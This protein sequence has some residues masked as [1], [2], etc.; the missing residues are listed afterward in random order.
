MTTEAIVRQAQPAQLH[1]RPVAELAPGVAGLLA[2]PGFVRLCLSNGLAQSFGQRMQGIAVAWLVLEMTGST[3]WL[4]VVNGVPAISIVL[5]SLVG[6]VVADSR[7][8]RRVLL[9]TRAVLT[10]TAFVTAVLVATGGVSIEH[11][12]LYV[13]IVVGVAAIDMP[14]SRN[15][16]HD[17]VGSERLLSASS[18]QSVLMNLVNIVAPVTI[19]LLIS[20]GGS[21]MA[22]WLLGVGYAIAVIL[23]LRTR[24]TAVERPQKASSPLSDIAAGLGYIRS[25]PKV[26]ALVSLA[27]L[28]PVAGVYFAMVP[29]YARDVLDVGAT[30][31]GVLVASFSVGSLLGSLYLAANGRIARGTLSLTI[32]GVAFGAGMIVFSVS[33][34]FLLSC[35]VSFGMGLMAGFWQNMLGALV[36]T[37]AAPEMRGRVTSVSTMGYQLMGVG[38]LLGGS[39]AALVGVQATVFGAGVFF[40]AMSLVVFALNKEARWID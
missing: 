11:L 30:G 38:W 12:L 2:V 19:G 16:V 7:D 22:F 34:S 39:S 10:V 21:S 3:F 15:M 8:A 40:T 26:A 9:M 36:Q 25:T 32:L 18:T 27:F 4:G 13:L 24:V 1:G 14:V 6:G 37:A 23:L 28:V 33:Q 20:S 31:L 5:F 17:L 29:V 35:S